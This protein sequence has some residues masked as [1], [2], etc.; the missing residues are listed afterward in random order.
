MNTPTTTE[1]LDRVKR[2][3][4]ELM[5]DRLSSHMMTV[6]KSRILA[7]EVLDKLKTVSQGNDI[8]H[9]L[10]ELEKDFAEMHF[11]VMQEKEIKEH[12]MKE[13][14][15]KHIGKMIRNGDIKT[16]TNKI[17]EIIGE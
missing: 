17:N 15:E 2:E 9:M 13:L 14:L 12:E 7:R 10:V 5:I 1:D 16:A 3:I 11:V 8:E 6:E 4:V